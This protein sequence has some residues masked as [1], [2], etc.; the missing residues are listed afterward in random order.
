MYNKGHD[1]NNSQ[2]LITLKT[3]PQFD[4]KFVVF[5]H[6]S[7]G[8]SVLR[9]MASIPTDFHDRPKVKI[10]IYDCGS[11]DKKA[12]I[13]KRDVFKETIDGILAERRLK[14]KVRILGPEEIEEYKRKNEEGKLGAESGRDFG[15][16]KGN[17]GSVNGEGSVNE[18]SDGKSEDEGNG[19]CVNIT[20]G[21]KEDADEESDSGSEEILKMLKSTSERHNKIPKGSKKEN[22]TIEMMYKEMIGKVTEAINE[23]NEE[24]LKGDEE[25]NKSFDWRGAKREKERLLKV[26]GIP[27]EKEY[28]LESINFCDKKNESREKKEKNKTFAWDIFNQGAYYRAHEKRLKNLPFD[29]VLYKEQSKGDFDIEKINSKTKIDLLIKDA[30]EQREK[31]EKFSRRRRYREEENVD[32]VNENNKKF[33]EKLRRYYGKETEGIRI[34]LERGTNV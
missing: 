19:E 12:Q 25:K 3:C 16:D 21:M 10:F 14:E 26:R 22:K 17:E 11:F 2:F 29:G 9:E 24:I 32:F 28:V 7:K 31:Q 6:V 13:F 18:G 15:E 5:G 4:S 23:N 1:K 8:M 34:N 20:Y 33:N 30:E 27:K